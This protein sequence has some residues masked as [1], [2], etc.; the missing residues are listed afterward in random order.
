MRSEKA[1][2]W[3]AAGVL[4]LG[5]NGAYQDGQLGWAHV[6]A[7]RATAAVERVN[8]R[9]Q[10][11]LAMAEIMLG[12]NNDTFSNSFSHAENVLERVQNKIVCDRVAHAQRQIAMAHVREQ[13]TQA[14]VQ[15]KVA[16]AQMKWNKMRMISIDRANEFNNCAGFSKVVV[17]VPDLPKIDLS[18]IPDIQVPDVPDFD[19]MGGSHDNGPI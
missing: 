15:Q 4:A 9:G 2:Y 11:F 10:R 13:L 16:M 7:D 19:S 6:V 12:S 1:W 3:L 14:R 5:L 8:V 17:N 18:N